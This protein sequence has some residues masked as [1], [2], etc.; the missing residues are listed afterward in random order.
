[1]SETGRVAFPA[2]ACNELT[3]PFWAAADEG[4]LVYMHCGECGHNWLPAREDCPNCLAPDPM[5]ETA[6]GDA[7]LVSWVVYHMAYD[8]AFAD[9]LPY[10]CAVVELAEG[11]RFVSNIVGIDDLGSLRIEQPLRLRIEDE[12]T[13]RVPRFVPA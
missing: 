11:A 3:R 8:P 10:V 7:T 4:R 13:V 12:G 5:W 9:R 6:S 1:M 2:P